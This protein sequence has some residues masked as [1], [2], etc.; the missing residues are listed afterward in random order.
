E[1]LDRHRERLGELAAHREDAALRDLDVSAV[2]GRRRR[3]ADPDRPAL[4]THGDGDRRARRIEAERLAIE[5]LHLVIERGELER[6][7]ELID[8]LLVGGDAGVAGADPPRALALVVL[9]A[10]E[11]LT[12]AVRPGDGDLGDRVT[13]PA[14][15]ERVFP[16][17]GLAGR[18]LPPVD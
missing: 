18:R 17:L 16:L 3:A 14:R 9:L 5:A 7:E 10:A 8:G 13:V 12:L 15:K 6:A 4:R 11:D 1:G 2:G